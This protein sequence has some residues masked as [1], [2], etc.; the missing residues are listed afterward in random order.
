VGESSL[1]TSSSTNHVLRRVRAA[2]IKRL[3][4]PL[5]PLLKKSKRREGGAW[6]SDYEVF[7]GLE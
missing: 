6:N 5:F 1:L 4:T 7:V 3:D 2:F